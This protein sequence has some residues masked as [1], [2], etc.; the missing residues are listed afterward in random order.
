MGW[1]VEDGSTAPRL[2]PLQDL[3]KFTGQVYIV[4][5][6]RRLERGREHPTT[7]EAAPA[8]AQIHRA[9]VHCRHCEAA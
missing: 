1:E 7:I 9:G 5:T 2:K 4:G 8:T 3:R 6:A